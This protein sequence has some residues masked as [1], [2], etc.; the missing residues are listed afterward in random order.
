MMGS[1]E[2]LQRT[3]GYQFRDLTL[4]QVALTHRSAGGHHNERLE[5]LGDAVLGFVVAER[6]FRDRPAAREGELSRLRARLVR[7]ET[8][9]D[10]ARELLLGEYLHMGTGELKSGGFQRDSIL[11]DALE[12]VIGA[13]YLD[14][15]VEAARELIERLLATQLRDLPEVADL[16]DAKTR[17][18]EILQA[19]QLAVPDYR[20]LAEGGEAHRPSFTVECSIPELEIR[21]T[22]LG[23]SR[24]AA[25]QA[26]AKQ[27]LS[28]VNHGKP[29]A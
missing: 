1:E 22:A 17:L 19:R 2:R 3:L 16:R 4:L 26:A 18:Q 28:Q 15:G 10:L 27:A 23:R 14:A 24:R 9:A 11:A 8:L 25:E 29:M 13:V 5:Y 21:T 20:I 12:A 7:R 6:L